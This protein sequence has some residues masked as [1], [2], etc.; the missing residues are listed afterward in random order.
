LIS[1]AREGYGSSSAEPHPL[2]GEPRQHKLRGYSCT[3]RSVNNVGGLVR[4]NLS[5]CHFCW[6]RRW[7]W[8]VA[9][10]L[11]QRR[12]R[13][14]VRRRVTR[15]RRKR[16]QCSPACPCCFLDT[17]GCASSTQNQPR[18]P[19]RTAKSLQTCGQAGP[20]P[21]LQ[22]RGGGWSGCTREPAERS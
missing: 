15:R 21:A 4:A 17:T 7:D 3:H 8:R 6:W 12:S 5:A 10:T 22:S 1:G 14:R 11:Q 20:R 2:T 16:R 13:V 19:P 18:P 9:A